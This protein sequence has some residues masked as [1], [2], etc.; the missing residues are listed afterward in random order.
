M[1]KRQ[2]KKA[3]KNGMKAA[4]CGI[5]NDYYYGI[6]R[7]VKEGKKYIVVFKSLNMHDTYGDVCRLYSQKGNFIRD[8]Y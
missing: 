6:K 7:I 2:F 8:L 1:N 3:I 4:T 5:C